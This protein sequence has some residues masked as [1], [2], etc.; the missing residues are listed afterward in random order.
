E[1]QSMDAGAT[2][3]GTHRALVQGQA[4]PHTQERALRR[5]DTQDPGGEDP[6]TD[7]HDQHRHSA[8]ELHHHAA[9]PPDR[10]RARQPA[11]PEDQTEEQGEHDRVCR[12]HQGVLQAGEEI[13]Q[14]GTGLDDRC[15]QFTGQL[16]VS[17]QL[18]D[19]ECGDPQQHDGRDDIA[20]ECAPAAAWAGRI[21][22]DGLCAHRDTARRC[23]SKVV[24]RPTGIT[25][26]TN[27]A[28]MARKMGITRFPCA[29][30]M[31]FI[32]IA[33]SSTEMAAA[34]VVFLI[35]AM[36]VFPKGAMAPRKACGMMT[37]RAVGRKDSPIAR[38]ASACPR[39]TVL[40]PER[41]DSHTNEAVYTVRASTANQKKF[42]EKSSENCTPSWVHRA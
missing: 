35:S 13:V 24:A 22:E 5:G 39:S 31:A 17:V 27:P 4:D 33:T 14:P 1:A 19:H 7:H 12:R 11:D 8:E 40:T 34:T 21:E 23:E 25:M 16:A 6:C 2:H 28:A 20:D 36:K 3:H 37:S 41:S 38:A 10:S 18:V 26:T 15:P 42:V 29:S 32:S 30:I 9:D